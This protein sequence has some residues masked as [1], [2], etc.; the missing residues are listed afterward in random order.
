MGS[1]SGWR[2]VRATLSRRESPSPSLEQVLAL[3]SRLDGTA[4]ELGIEGDPGGRYLVAGGGPSR[5]V[6]FCQ[7]DAFG[8]HNL[9]D[10][11]AEADG[12]VT[13][14]LSGVDTPIEVRRTVPGELVERAIRYFFATGEI[15]PQLQW[16]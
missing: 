2:V 3:F 10:P 5:F 14:L 11:T 15:D 7:G 4:G 1:A 12:W 9:V 13:L 8:P 16:E 6:L